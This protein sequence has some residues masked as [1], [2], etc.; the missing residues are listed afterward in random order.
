MYPEDVPAA[1]VYLI[2]LLCSGKRINARLQGYLSHHHISMRIRMDDTLVTITSAS[3]L[4]HAIE[5][6]TVPF[7]QQALVL[8]L[9]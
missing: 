9:H 5:F 4:F 7:V 2:Q 6:Q 3:P 1:V 8:A